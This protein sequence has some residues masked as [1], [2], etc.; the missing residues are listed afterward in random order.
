MNKHNLLG[1]SNQEAME[2]LKQAMSNQNTVHLVVARR[3]TPTSHSMP[4]VGEEPEEVGEIST[5]CTYCM[6]MYMYMQEEE[7]MEHERNEVGIDVPSA[8]AIP[9]HVNTLT[10]GSPHSLRAT[11]S[12]HNL[13]VGGGSGPLSSLQLQ[14]SLEHS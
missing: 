11:S 13:P 3:T 6:Y 8:S 10:T 9:P 7:N 4:S 12:A 2:I 5:S 1:H 14:T